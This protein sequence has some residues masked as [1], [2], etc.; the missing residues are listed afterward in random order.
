MTKP[1]DPLIPGLG[2]A[3]IPAVGDPSAGAASD[4]SGGLLAALARLAQPPVANGLYYN[5]KKLQLDGYKFTWC[6]FDACHLVVASTN[7]E[8]DHCIIDIETVIEWKGDV[9]KA[10]QLFNAKYDWA[11]TN[12][13]AF[14]PTRNQDGTISITK[15]S[16]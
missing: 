15:P 13:P 16:Q 9:I 5:R 2:G 4:F 8:L 12:F 1:G 11:Y 10:I 6:R 14:A 7:F 3:L